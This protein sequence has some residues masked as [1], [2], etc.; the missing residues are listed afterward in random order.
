MSGLVGDIKGQSLSLQQ[1]HRLR[2]FAV[3]ARPVENPT[4]QMFALAAQAK[5]LVDLPSKVQGL[6]LVHVCTVPYSSVL[7][8]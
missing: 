6:H 3:R 4:V 1:T 8:P 7:I 5:L 2:G